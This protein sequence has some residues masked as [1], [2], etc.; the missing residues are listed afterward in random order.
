MYY[1]TLVYLNYLS[2]KEHVIDQILFKFNN[3]LRVVR[4]KFLNK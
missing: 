2:M 3:I 1:A 4:L